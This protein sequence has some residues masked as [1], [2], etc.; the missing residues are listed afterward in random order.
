MN[1]L[2]EA[3]KKFKWEQI[4][5]AI[6]SIVVGILFIALPESSADALCTICGVMLICAGISIIIAYIAYGIFFAA[7]LLILGIALILLGVFAISNPNAIKGIL[8]IVFGIYIIVD[9]SS[10]LV[11]SILCAKAKIKGW[12]LLLLISIMTIVLG[13]VVMFGSFEYIMTFAG[14]CIIIDGVCDLIET[15]VFSHRIR[16][17]KKMLLQKYNAIDEIK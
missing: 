13:S 10:S 8:T 9:G 17:A 3:F 4:V 14:V 16:E 15:L 6:V 12:F 5:L 2:K 11:D 1:L 7:H